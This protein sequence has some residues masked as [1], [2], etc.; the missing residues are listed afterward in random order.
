[1]NTIAYLIWIATLSTSGGQYKD[2]YPVTDL[3]TCLEIVS[4]AQVKV[5]NGGDAEST[6]TIFCATQKPT[7]SPK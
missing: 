6:V 3:K 4:K 5:P 7:W 1:M 2:Y